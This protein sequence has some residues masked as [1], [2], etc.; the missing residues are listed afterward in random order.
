MWGANILIGLAGV[1]LTVRSAKETLLINWTWVAR[2][3]PKRLRSEQ[4]A[5]SVP[6]TR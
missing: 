3:V 5:E 2:L 1:Y 6:H 4:E